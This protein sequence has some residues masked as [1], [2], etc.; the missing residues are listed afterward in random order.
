VVVVDED[1]VWVP[2]VQG[3]GLIVEV[4]QWVEDTDEVEHKVGEALKDPVMVEDEH[5]VADELKDP[6]TVDVKHKLGVGL[7]V[8]VVDED[9]DL[10]PEVQGDGLI[11]EVE[12]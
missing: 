1:T 11:V 7:T 8:V 9:T 2:E 5:K 12:Q 6:V 3:D 10:V 4:E